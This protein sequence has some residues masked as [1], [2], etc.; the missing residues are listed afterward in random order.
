MGSVVPLAAETS[1]DESLYVRIIAEAPLERLDLIR[2]GAVIDSLALE[3]RLEAV[4]E[5][6]IKDLHP[7]DYVYVRAVQQDGGA[8][9][10]SPIYFVEA[11]PQKAN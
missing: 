6:P 8:A 9:W 7:G 10:S 3:G 5:R 4:L 11:S 1:T 2:S